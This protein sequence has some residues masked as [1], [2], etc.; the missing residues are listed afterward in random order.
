[1]KLSFWG[2]GNLARED[3]FVVEEGIE[4]S[5]KTYEVIGGLMKI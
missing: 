4:G 2:E 1:M 5:R 3:G